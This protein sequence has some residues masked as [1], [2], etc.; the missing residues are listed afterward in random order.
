MLSGT[1]ALSRP[2][3]LFTVLNIL[4][5]RKWHSSK[6]FI[7]RYCRAKKKRGKKLKPG[8]EYKGASNTHELHLIL[9]DTLMIRVS[10]GTY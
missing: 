6:D 5:P 1:P 10:K 9:T 2:I 4:D 7:A 3:E 8:S